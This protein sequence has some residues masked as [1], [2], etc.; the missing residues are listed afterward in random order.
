MKGIMLRVSVPALLG[1][2]FSFTGCKSLATIVPGRAPV[3]KET[4]VPAKKAA[5]AHLNTQPLFLIERN[6][7]AN[8]V[9][10]EAVFTDAGELDPAGPVIAYWVLLAE[11]GRR[12]KLN[13]LEKKK[14]Y[15]IKI[16]PAPNGYILTLASASWLPLL[17][18]KDGDAAHAE[19]KIKDRPVILEKMFIQAR[20]KLL[21]PK[22]EY[23]EVFGKDL[24]TGAPCREKIFPE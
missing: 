2:L 23:I 6:K 4:A 1:A 18:K 10:Y 24:E 21:G 19:V 12:K 3:P 14:A 17:V 13:W 9:H 15:G 22:V 20:E 8:V 5:A 7:N 11:D 16:K